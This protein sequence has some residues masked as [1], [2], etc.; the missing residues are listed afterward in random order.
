MKLL[1][2][3]SMLAAFLTLCTIG[4]SQ[5]TT[6]YNNPEK[7]DVSKKE[8]RISL[9]LEKDSFYMSQPYQYILPILGAQAHKK[10]YRFLLPFGVMINAVS[11]QQRLAIDDVNI[12]FG[13]KNSEAEPVMYN[14]NNIVDF[15]PIEATTSTYNVRVDVW[16]L[17][18]LDIYGMYGKVQKANI[19]IKMIEPFPLTVATDVAGYY[20]GYGGMVNGKVGPVFLSLDANTSVNHNPRLNKPVR[21]SL[22]SAR[23]G[24]I[25][26]VNRNPDMKILFWTGLMYTN[27]GA[28]TKGSINTIDL[29]PNAPQKIDDM[30]SDMDIW[31]NNLGT[32]DKIKY[33]PIYNAL[34]NGLGFL[35]TGINDTYIKYSMNKKV[36][37]PWNMLIGVQWQIDKHW[38][39]RSEGQVL[40]DRKALLFSFNYRFGIKGHN[41]FSN[42]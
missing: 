20:L 11:A 6:V 9:L 2:L 7:K 29:A 17:P 41:W 3:I 22:V 4:Y 31:Y 26:Q 18:F 42:L 38:Q 24:P 27:Y 8:K 30:Q 35:N 21:I 33:T 25:F 34:T 37:R 23:T 10:G 36:E 14:L 1:K 40:G 5:D 13:N 16:P 19:A 32:L 39:V 28:S 15:E 12:G